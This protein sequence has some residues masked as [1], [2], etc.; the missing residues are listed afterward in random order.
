VGNPNNKV[1]IET[2][3]EGEENTEITG[4]IKEGDF[5]LY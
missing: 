1:Y 3:L 4:D 5:L 2:G